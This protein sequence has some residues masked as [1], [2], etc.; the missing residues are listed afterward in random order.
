MLLVEHMIISTDSL[1]VIHGLVS[2]IDVQNVQVLCTMYYLSWKRTPTTSILG[3][4][5]CYDIQK[6]LNSVFPVY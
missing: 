6:K 4:F 5:L 2:I 3:L 1:I